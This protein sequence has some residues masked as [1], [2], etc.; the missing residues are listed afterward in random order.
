MTALGN[1]RWRAR[2]R[3]SRASARYEYTVAG[4]DRPASRRGATSCARWTDAADI[5]TRARSRRRHHRGLAAARART[6]TR[7]R[8][9]T[10]A[11]G[12]QRRATRS[13]QA[14]RA[15]DDDADRA[16]ACATPIAASPRPREPV[17]AVAVEPRARRLLARGT[18]CSRARPRDGRRARHVR[19][20]RGAAAATSRTWAST[21]CTC[22]PSIRSARPSARA[23]TTR[24]SPR[25]ASPAARGPSARAEGGHKAIH[26]EL[27]TRGGLPAAGR[28]GA[29]R[30]GIEI[31]LDIAFQSSPDHPYVERASAVVPAIART[32]PSSTPRIRRRNTRTSIRSTS[33]PTTGRRCGR[34]CSSVFTLLD[35]RRACAIFR[36]DNPH[37]KPFA[38][39]EWMIGEIKARASRGD[40][41]VRGVHAAAAHAPARQ[42]RLHA[43]VH[44]L[45]VAQHQGGAHRILHR[46]RAGP[47]ARLLPANVW[48][49]TPDILHRIPADAALRPAFI[50]R[51][52]LAGTLSANYG[53]YGP[54]FELM[55]HVP[56]EPGS[57]EY[58]DSE[59]YEIKALGPRARRQPARRS[60]RA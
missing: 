19:R 41:P 43:V 26:P 45:H 36:V 55:E 47:V 3:R 49:N 35:R 33:S 15:L 7:E 10:G 31:A 18:R 17:L 28:G 30:S 1:D 21:S 38:F 13:A 48:P 4:V 46:A 29:R 52:V 5:E 53:I 39:W 6:R 8:C 58:L 44:L 23:A 50:A 60:S 42:A 16:R 57:E 24:S 9:A 27:G 56:R 40:L 59:K 2:V 54:A 22:R 20:R 51:L 12:S 25:R 32:A 11:R 37:T 14:H 34:S